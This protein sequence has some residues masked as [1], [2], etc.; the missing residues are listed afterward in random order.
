VVDKSEKSIFRVLVLSRW[1]FAYVESDSSQM[2]INYI[3][4]WGPVMDRNQLQK[5]QFN[6]AH[7][8]TMP[9]SRQ[10]PFLKRNIAKKNPKTKLFGFNELEFCLNDNA[11]IRLFNHSKEDVLINRKATQPKKKPHIIKNHVR[12]S[13]TRLLSG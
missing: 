11:E 7:Y 5:T 3:P 8:L 12:N 1:K 13:L 2:T 6:V 4:T 9:Q 10:R